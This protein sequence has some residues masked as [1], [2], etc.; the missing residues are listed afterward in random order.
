M[1][2]FV[3]NTNEHLREKLEMLESLRDIE[4]ATKFVDE[5]HQTDQSIYDEY[6]KKL[7]CQIFPLAKDNDMYEIV[8]Q[9]FKNTT[10]DNPYQKYEL[11]D[12]YEIFKPV[13]INQD[14]VN[15]RMLWYATR[16]TNY[17]SVLDN[18]F[19]FPPEEA[20]LSGYPFGKGIYFSD[21]ASESL[22]QCFPSNGIGLI[23]LCEVRLGESL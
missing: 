9:S 6:L 2:K 14:I 13:D 20:P 5:T 19:K 22:G 16:L 11:L 21:M 23:L 12:I 1:S 15:R 18:G 7:N 8:S 17:V 4:V 10:S 3:I